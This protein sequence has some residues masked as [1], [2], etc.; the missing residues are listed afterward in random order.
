MPAFPTRCQHPAGVVRLWL[1]CGVRTLGQPNS[2]WAGDRG[3]PDPDVRAAL[4]RAAG[5]QNQT[6]YLLAV[7][8][9]CGARLLLPIVA[10]GD[11]GSGG[12][13]PERHAEL[14]AVLMR[15]ASGQS[16]ALA[17]TG[18]DALQAFDPQARPVPC[19][20]DVVASTAK[21]VGATAIVIDVAGPQA[22]VIDESLIGPLAL[23]N[24]L[25][26]LDEG[27]GWLS[28][29]STGGDGLD[30]PG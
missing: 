6:E 2:G 25:V 22:L 12:P 14:A 28:A 5:S 11:E 15:S 17:F 4:A 7:S 18:L 26:K 16:G 30:R 19:T 29:V 23:G 27:W 20:L 24:R 9:L 3:E 13:D 1:A 10:G 8:A 21:E